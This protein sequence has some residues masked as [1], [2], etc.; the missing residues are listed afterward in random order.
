MKDDAMHGVAKKRLARRHGA[1]DSLGAKFVMDSR[2]SHLPLTPRSPLKPMASATQR[3]T[4]SEEW[5]L[6]LS[7]TIVYDEVQLRL[8]RA[9]SKKEG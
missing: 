9:R 7:M 6:R 4:D 5:V 3:T 2:I 8:R 1:M